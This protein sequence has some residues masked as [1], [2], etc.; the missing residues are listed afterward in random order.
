MK[1]RTLNNQDGIALGPILFIIAILAILAA[2]IAAGTGE[3]S[4]NTKTE[5]AKAMAEVLIQ[6][7]EDFKSAFQNMNTNWDVSQFDVTSN[8]GF[9]YGNPQPNAACTDSSCHLF[10]PSGGGVNATPLPPSFSASN[11]RWLGTGTTITIRYGRFPG[12]GSNSSIFVEFL[13][14]DPNVCAAIDNL[15]NIPLVAGLPPSIGESPNLG[16]YSGN[17]TT[18]TMD[19]LPA[20]YVYGDMG[21]KNVGL[22]EF[23]VNSGGGVPYYYFVVV[24]VVR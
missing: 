1:Q 6:K 21:S 22:T 11:S 3:F 17:I 24:V 10:N 15:L 2:A 14:L 19:S 7:A 23:C 20:G 13:D 4:A 5:S 8:T 9:V 12:V 18:T 16:D